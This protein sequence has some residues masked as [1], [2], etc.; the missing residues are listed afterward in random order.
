MC[1]YAEKTLGGMLR[2]LKRDSVFTVSFP[3]HVK[4]KYVSTAVE[5]GIQPTL[6]SLVA[7]LFLSSEIKNENMLYFA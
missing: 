1:V 2:W 6:L 5:G 3:E 7:I 4:F